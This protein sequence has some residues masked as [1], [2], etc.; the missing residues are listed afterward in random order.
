MINY[1]PGTWGFSVVFQLQGSVFP[2]AFMLSVTS[3]GITV[4]AFFVQQEYWAGTDFEASD[5]MAAMWSGFTFVLGFLVVF[6]TQ[7]AYSRYWEGASL[8]KIMRSK[9]FNATSN[10]MAFCN[11]STEKDMVKD[12]EAFQNLT[13]RLMSL[14][15]VSGL[16]TVAAFHDDHF[17]MIDTSGMEMSQMQFL[18]KVHDKRHRC[19]ILLQW[20]QKSIMENLDK[21]VLSAPPPILGRVFQELGG[22]HDSLV[23][24]RKMTELPFPFPYAQMISV[25]LM[26]HWLLCPCV[27]IFLTKSLLWSCVLTF[28]QVTALWGINYIAAEIES[29]FG[30]DANDLDLEEMAID[31]NDSLF[32]LL[33]RNTQRPPKLNTNSM[34]SLKK[35]VTTEARLSLQA[36]RPDALQSAIQR[37][38]SSGDFEEQP[39]D[40][41][42]QP[43]DVENPQPGS[44]FSRHI[45]KAPNPLPALL[46][47]P[48]ILSDVPAASPACTSEAATQNLLSETVQMENVEKMLTSL[49]AELVELRVARHRGLCEIEDFNPPRAALLQQAR[50]RLLVED[51]SS[52]RQASTPFAKT[53]VFSSHL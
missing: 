20:L 40:L 34:Y 16:Q 7:Q 5:K 6:R 27:S 38:I 9:W 45:L 50:K 10:L 8:L 52:Q 46:L 23:L 42:E 49:I 13:V 4:A 15:Y 33:E 48:P 25:L 21:K 19:E 11:S 17:L 44:P 41:E 18:A 39:K 12:V 3:T 31:M 32:L 14:L 30:R 28:L 35:R 22:G 43:K 51:D 47:P 37:A 1:E 36:Q 24:A 53:E 26:L 29:P 2:K